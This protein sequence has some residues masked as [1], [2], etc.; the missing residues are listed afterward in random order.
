MNSPA[1][2]LF[3]AF[4]RSTSSLGQ[5]SS[6]ERDMFLQQS[7]NQSQFAPGLR[8]AIKMISSGAWADLAGMFAPVCSSFCAA[9]QG[10]ACRDLLNGWGNVFHIS[11]QCGNKMMSRTQA[12][13]RIF[14]ALVF[15]ICSD[16]FNFSPAWLPKFDTIT[17]KRLSIW[18]TYMVL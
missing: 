11:I 13:C 12:T 14:W 6:L 17:S 2:Y 4:E 8:L 3:L 16:I 1:G 5:K 10:T 7:L 18:F 9:N 15:T